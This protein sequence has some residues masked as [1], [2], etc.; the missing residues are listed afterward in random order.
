MNLRKTVDKLCSPAYFYLVVA[1][2]FF[3]LMLVQNIYNGDLQELCIGSFTCQVSNVVVLF[4]LQLLYISFWTFVL[5]A[6]C[7]YGFKKLSW[8]IA[9][10]PFLLSAVIIGIFLVSKIN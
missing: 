7:D 10:F 6:L 3:I 4:L 9:L 2:T 1:L 8:F 5:N